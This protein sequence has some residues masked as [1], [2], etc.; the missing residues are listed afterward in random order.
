MGLM[1]QILSTSLQYYGLEKLTS[2]IS[3]FGGTA[4]VVFLAA[5]LTIFSGPGSFILSIIQLIFQC[6]LTLSLLV[7]ALRAKPKDSM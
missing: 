1:G 5:A 2:K 4:Y 3:F 6:F 7:V